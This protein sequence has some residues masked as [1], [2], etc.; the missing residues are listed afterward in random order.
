LLIGIPLSLL[1]SFGAALPFF[2][3]LFFFALFGLMVGAAVFRV[4]A[5]GRPYP[6]AAVLVLTSVVVGWCMGISLLKEAADF[7]NNMAD[8]AV[9]RTRNIG[10]LTRNEYHA[11][12]AEEVR[13][14]LADR[15]PPGGWIGYFRWVTGS[16]SIEKGTLPSV[17][18]SLSPAYTG[19]LWMVR[20]VLSL[21]LL[22][23]GIA[24]QTLLLSH[25][26]K[27]EPTDHVALP[28]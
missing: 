6:R 1:L 26:P 3:G 9:S 23:F 13:S 7:P 28:G 20:V 14:M 17:D 4:G 25:A 8:Q 12:V 21:S 15:F 22:T 27:A 19:M 16:A 10:S 24:S 11:Q 18:R 5:P 2:I